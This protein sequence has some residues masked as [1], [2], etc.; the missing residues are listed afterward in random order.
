[1]KKLFIFLLNIFLL[2]SCGGGGGGGEAAPTGSSTPTPT[3]TSTNNAPTINNATTDYSI[4]ENQTVAFTVSATDPDE[5]TLS[6]SISGSDSSKLNIDSNGAVTFQSAPDYDNPIDIGTNNIYDFSVSVS[7]GTLSAAEN[8]TITVTDQTE[9]IDYYADPTTDPEYVTSNYHPK[10]C[11]IEKEDEARHWLW[12]AGLTDEQKT[13]IYTDGQDVTVTGGETY[14]INCM[15]DYQLN[16]GIYVSG[17]ASQERQDLGLYGVSFYTRIYRELNVIPV[18]QAGVWGQWIQP[19]RLHPHLTFQSI[20]GGVFLDDKMGRSLYP[21]YMASGATHV[22]NPNSSQFGWGFYEKRVS[23]DYYA[24]IQ[25]ANTLLYPP[26]LLSFDEDQDSYSTNGGIFFGHAWIALPM[27]GGKT[28]S[29]WVTA[30][31]G[32]SERS[33]DSGKLTWTFFADAKNFSGPVHAYVPEMWYRR[34]DNLNALEILGDT[35]WDTNAPLTAKLKDLFAERIT[36]DDIMTIVSA[37]SWYADGTENYTSGPYWIR[38]K[39]TFAYNPAGGIAIGAERDPTW[40]L[41][42][43]DDEGNLYLK[44]FLPQIPD[45]FNL[46]PFTLSG[47]SYSVEYYNNFVSFFNT[48]QEISTVSF[49]I[50]SFTYPLEV[51]PETRTEPN[52]F[53][54]VDDEDDLAEF[55]WKDVSGVTNKQQFNLGVNTTVQEINRGVDVYFNWKNA[56]ERMFSQY[57]KVIP[58][59]QL[60]NYQFIR[61]LE[62]EVP[63][64]LKSNTYQNRK[65]VYSL[66]PHEKTS[67]DIEIENQMKTGTNTVFN[68]ETE[69]L[70]FSC[71]VCDINNGCDPS[72]YET[73]LDDGSKISYKWYKFKDQPTFQQ[74]KVDYPTVYTDEYLNSLQDKIEQI[75]DNWYNSKDFLSRPSTANGI[76]IKLAELDNGLIVTPPTNKAKGWVPIVLSVELPHGDWITDLNTVE[77]PDGLV[78]KDY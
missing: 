25:I 45:T 21:K 67:Q 4:I 8:F 22:Y 58:D 23:C 65:N 19:N 10:H 56:T 14:K 31:G 53:K 12:T 60:D 29:N 70:N 27:I 64:K 1:M 7:D 78:I 20:E 47:R 15:G 13:A 73:T 50:N 55:I 44:T 38:E 32:E 40:G 42:E 17:W 39:D 28:R 9:E 16:F 18:G 5:D 2:V 52:Q 43:T 62:S 69:P 34:L 6:Y 76:T 30:G 35:E 72:M 11:W 66:M 49:D 61:A 57:Y 46:E 63:E 74:L 41:T 48:P 68:I 77:G 54:T 24:G 33:L 51:E 59:A 71:W 26:N 36:H 75:H 37:E 3:P